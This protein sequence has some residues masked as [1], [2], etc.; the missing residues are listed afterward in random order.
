M[1]ELAPP[2]V[3]CILILILLIVFTIVL[4]IR[5]LFIPL[6]YTYDSIILEGLI[7]LVIVYYININLL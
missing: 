7:S 1:E 6:E 4:T 2:V 5:T 3:T